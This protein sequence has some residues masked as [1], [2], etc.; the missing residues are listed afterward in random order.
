MICGALCVII[1]YIDVGVSMIKKKVNYFKDGTHKTNV[2]VMISYRP[3]PGQKPKQKTIKNL[4][5]RQEN[6]E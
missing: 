4:K 2:R 6:T 1:Y 5:S 3:G